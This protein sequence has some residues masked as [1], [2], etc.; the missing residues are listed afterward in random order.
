[1]RADGTFAVD[2]E[3]PSAANYVRMDMD[4]IEQSVE[5]LIANSRGGLDYL[6]EVGEHALDYYEWSDPQRFRFDAAARQFRRVEESAN[7]A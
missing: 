1:M 7:D 5:D 4:V 6:I 3:M 2:R